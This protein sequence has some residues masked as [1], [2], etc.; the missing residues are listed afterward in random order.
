MQKRQAILTA[1]IS[2]ALLP[3]GGK[4]WKLGKVSDKSA[5]IDVEWF[6]AVGGTI[7]VWKAIEQRATYSPPEGFA[8]YMIRSDKP[9]IVE[10]YVTD[11][12]GSFDVDVDLT[13]QTIGVTNTATDPLYITTPPGQ[14]INVTVEAAQIAAIVAAEN[15]STAQLQTIVNLLDQ[16]NGCD[17]A[18]KVKI[19]EPDP[20]EYKLR[21]V[22]GDVSNNTI[23]FRTFDPAR[24]FWSMRNVHPED[25]WIAIGGDNL[26]DENATRVLRTGDTWYEDNP[27]IA[28]QP[29]FIRTV[30]NAQ[31]GGFPNGSDAIFTYEERI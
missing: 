19:C 18:F 25:V 4:Q 14:T 3:I 10:Y 16:P 23:N 21:N 20:T 8:S 29:I 1:A 11:G 2:Y 22:R 9:V 28:R 31:G 24:Q 12:T 27:L 6:N 13:G 17:D 30:P 5:K 26:D 7:A 15:A